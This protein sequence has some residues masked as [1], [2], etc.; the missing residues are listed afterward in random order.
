MKIDL[1]SVF[2]CCKAVIGHMMERR[3]GKI[4][5]ISSFAGKGGNPHLVPY[6]AAKAGVINL[7]RTLALTVAYD[8]DQRQLCLRRDRP[9]SDV[10]AIARCAN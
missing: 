1:K 2:I 5:N 9:H 6:S 7:S 3:Y 8:G 4:I 10:E